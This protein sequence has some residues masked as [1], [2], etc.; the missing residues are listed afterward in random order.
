MRF[1]ARRT[2]GFVVLLSIAVGRC[3]AEEPLWEPESSFVHTERKFANVDCA[4]FSDDD[5]FVEVHSSIPDETNG[6]T[7]IG[8]F[9]YDVQTGK[10]DDTVRGGYG[11]Y[12]YPTPKSLRGT[13]VLHAE[14]S[15]QKRFIL[16]QT[17][18]AFHLFDSEEKALY[19]IPAEKDANVWFGQNDDAL[20]V[21]N[22]NGFR[23]YATQTGAVKLDVELGYRPN[24]VGFSNGK[25]YLI[26][27]FSTDTYMFSD[28]TIEVVELSTGKRHGPFKGRPDTF[29]SDD[30]Y[31]T[32]RAKTKDD[33]FTLE[34]RKLPSFEL[35]AT[36]KN[37]YSAAFIRNNR[38]LLL[39]DYEDRKSGLSAWDIAKGRR[40]WSSPIAQGKG[41]FSEIIGQ[42]KVVCVQEPGKPRILDITTGRKLFNFRKRP[43]FAEVDLARIGF[44]F[45]HT[46]MRFLTYWHLDDKHTKM[47]VIVWKP[48]RAI[49]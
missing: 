12:R 9:R 22:T 24:Y 1:D 14:F 35:A 5:E 19:V 6:P 7:S 32:I 23:L 21:S 39:L 49:K 13:E 37:G 30:D 46:S 48:V 45:S 16:A 15:G 8:F 18:D 4:A 43:E 36:I 31:F 33:G 20:L 25:K 27:G 26:S 47:Q 11:E 44:G 3:W 34:L 17:K 28:Y 38:Y 41:H 42:D 40:V 2:A 29:S 10:G